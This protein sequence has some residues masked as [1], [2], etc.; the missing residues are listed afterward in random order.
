V[1][2]QPAANQVLTAWGLKEFYDM[3][4]VH[5]VDPAVIQRT[6]SGSSAVSR[7]TAPG[8]PTSSTCTRSR[9]RHPEEQY[10]GDGVRARRDT[11]QREKAA[12]PETQKAIDYLRGAGRSRQA[13]RARADRQRARLV[14]AKDPW[15][16]QVLD[17]LYGMRQDD[18][19]A[20]YWKAAPTR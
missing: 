6:R 8:S 20:V 11:E 18:K 12:G 5:E 10:A 14:N 1:V 9:G 15:T 19:D 4:Q 7:A 3:S 16:G 13:L 17:K 2:R